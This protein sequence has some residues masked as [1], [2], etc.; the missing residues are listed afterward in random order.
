[1]NAQDYPF[2]TT[3]PVRLRDLDVFDHVNNAVYFTY[4]EAAR[5][6]FMKQALNISRPEEI[7]FI[8]GDAYCRFVSPVFYGETVVVGLGISRFGTKSLDIVY[9]LETGDGRLVALGRTGMVTYDYQ[10]GHSIPIPAALRAQIE[11]FQGDW[12]P[13]ATGS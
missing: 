9:R 13:P 11:A 12:Q 5:G 4:M 1:M 7:P 3:I 6:D 10:A 8:V 2:H